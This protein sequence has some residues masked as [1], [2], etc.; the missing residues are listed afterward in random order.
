MSKRTQ[1]KEQQTTQVVPKNTSPKGEPR[2]WFAHTTMHPGGSLG[3][4]DAKTTPRGPKTPPNHN[5]WLVC[6][7]SGLI[8]R[9]S[10]VHMFKNVRSVPAQWC[11]FGNAF[12]RQNIGHE[13]NKSRGLARSPHSWHSGGVAKGTWIFPIIRDP[14]NLKKVG[15]VW[16]LQKETQSWLQR[17]VCC[18]LVFNTYWQHGVTKKQHGANKRVQKSNAKPQSSRRNGMV[19][20]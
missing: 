1:N 18:T 13:T 6:L 4:L 15:A 7:P 3:P 16:S 14:Q 12:A 9:R 10:M 20:E 11:A 5:L 2:T 17:F 8:Y 19:T